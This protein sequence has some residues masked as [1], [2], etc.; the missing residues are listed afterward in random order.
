MFG[1]VDTDRLGFGVIRKAKA[2]WVGT[3]RAGHGVLSTD[4][5]VLTGVPYSF[6]TRFESGM[7]TN[8]EELLAAAHA[9]CFTM[10]LALRM[11]SVG[12]TPTE[13]NTEVAHHAL[14]PHSAR[15]SA[16]YDASHL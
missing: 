12:Y 13:L 4:A 11:Q 9:G 15:D 2:V 6:R 16:E 14:G 5:G 10:A 1:R 3:G 7:G 8:P